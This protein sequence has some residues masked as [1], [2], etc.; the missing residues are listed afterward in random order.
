MDM[1]G[2]KELRSVTF[3]GPFVFDYQSLL[4]EL[5]PCINSF[6]YDH[7]A[8]KVILGRESIGLNSFDIPLP[9]HRYDI[10]NALQII[11]DEGN[12]A[13][14]THKQTLVFAP[15]IKSEESK[16]VYRTLENLQEEKGWEIIVFCFLRSLQNPKGSWIPVNQIFPHTTT[17]YHLHKYLP[18]LIKNPRFDVIKWYKTLNNY[19]NSC[20]PKSETVVN[21]AFFATNGFY[22]PPLF[23]ILQSLIAIT[24]YFPDENVRFV[25]HPT[26]YFYDETNLLDKEFLNFYLKN[27]I[28]K[29]EAIL[30]SDYRFGASLNGLTSM[31]DTINKESK[32]S[33][34]NVFLIIADPGFLDDI[35]SN[36]NVVELF[37][38]S[39]HLQLYPISHFNPI[40]IQHAA[41][42]PTKCKAKEMFYRNIDIF[43]YD[44]FFEEVVKLVCN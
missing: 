18:T 7:Y 29:E 11:S 9:F 23:M 10:L 26:F 8:K 1:Y 42:I 2:C 21:I 4:E 6:F 25:L 40:E 39:K 14:N 43:N 5:G 37:K 20:S 13:N 38:T 15:Y 41:P 22:Q 28:V 36:K 12:K 24:N 17:N 3:L 32:A 16:M 33:I 19:H 35:C 34:R 31:I 44:H 27:Y 30:F